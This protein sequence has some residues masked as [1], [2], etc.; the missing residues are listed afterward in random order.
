MV[1]RNDKYWQERF[2]QVT[3]AQL[4]SG[5]NYYD[6]A[7]R[8]YRAA[9]ESIEKDIARW[10]MRLAKNNQIT[11][12]EAKKL[13]TNSQLKDFKLTLKEYIKRGKEN[14]VSADWN[15]SLENA[16]AKYH[17]SRLEALQMQIQQHLE[18]LY[19]N[20]LDGMDAAMRGIYRDSYYQ[21]AYELQK[22]FSTGF[23]VQ[24]IDN[25]RL[26]RLLAKPWAA[27][28]QNFSQRLWADKDKLINNLQN[29][30]VQGLVRGD[31][32]LKI[33]QRLAHKM[34]SSLSN[35]GRLIATESAY[36]ASLGEKDS[37]KELG[38]EQY[39]IL[40]TLDR[41][42]SE[43][44][45]SMDGKVFKMSEFKAG[46]T[47][48][49]LHPWCRS[50]TVPHIEGL[51]SGLRAARD[52]DGKVYYV[53]GNMKYREWK[54]KFVDGG[55]KEGL[56]EVTANILTKYNDLDTM[57]VYI[58]QKYGIDMNASV[59][60][61]NYDAVRA[62]MDG[63]EAVIAEYPD[64][65]TVLQTIETKQSGIMACS[66]NKITFNPQYFSDN[67]LVKLCKDQS[68][69]GWWPPNASISSVGAHEAGHA[70]EMV[71]IQNNP[72]YKYDFERAV[73]WNNCTE[74]KRIVSQACK[75]IKKTSYGKGKKKYNLI[76]AISRYAQSND[77]ETLAE[78]FA[79]VH[80]NGQNA[81]P[82]SIEI[83]RLTDEQLKQYKGGTP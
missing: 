21:T 37:M 52:D 9:M 59:K 70:V 60:A 75:N 65:G 55:D 25:A 48:P 6:E 41:R 43:I 49:P 16:S 53:P 71:L 81:N 61:L 27:D 1:T 82:L 72:A 33:V 78:A 14:G 26:D 58:K 3:E 23:D 38:V 67:K 66:G 7:E 32:Q 62:A 42:T 19:G 8:M 15:K 83:K 69:T 29:E 31:A 47:A 79:D 12:A 45:R 13:L 22:G 74:A 76:G 20:Q 34:N 57:A 77:S 80:A 40:A 63:V 39:E 35:A 17:I 73:A 54:K 44:C 18:E 51:D 2:E 30:L 46:V 50:C 28:G 64:V 24:Q 68:S 36:F 56:Q 4:K 5:M 11:Y 10:Y